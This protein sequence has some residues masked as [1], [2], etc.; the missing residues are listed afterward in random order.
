MGHSIAEAA[1]RSGLSIDTLRY[2]E[3]IK[4]LDPPE[5]D[6][7]GRRDYSEEDLTWLA[8]LTRLRT[9]GM[10]IRRMREYASLRRR[11]TASAGRRKAILVEQRAVV[12]ERIEELRACMDVLDYKIGNYERIERD[13]ALVPSEATA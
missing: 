1:R 11:G 7:A 13:A 5:R 6:A 8:F 9:T 4:L 12:A 2:Y 3:R 10:P